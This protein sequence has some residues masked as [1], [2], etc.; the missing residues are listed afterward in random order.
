MKR[1]MEKRGFRVG[2]PLFGL[3]VTERYSVQDYVIERHPV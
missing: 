1:Q 2:D 3:S